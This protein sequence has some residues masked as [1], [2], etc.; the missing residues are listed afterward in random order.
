[1]GFFFVANERQSTDCGNSLFHLCMGFIVNDRHLNLGFL[2]MCSCWCIMQERL[3]IMAFFVRSLA[4]PHEI[5]MHS[6]CIFQNPNFVMLWMTSQLLVIENKPQNLNQCH[7]QCDNKLPHRRSI[8]N[9]ISS[10]QFASIGFVC[11]DLFVFIFFVTTI[12]LPLSLSLQTFN[13]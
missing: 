2:T 7:K 4:K 13:T 5:E 11:F 6:I 12:S 9:I 10:I 1:M 3:S 8:S